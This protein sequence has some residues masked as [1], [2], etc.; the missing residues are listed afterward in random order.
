[1]DRRL[2]TRGQ[3]AIWGL[4]SMP[5]WRA[6]AFGLWLGLLAPALVLAQN[7]SPNTSNQPGSTPP[8]SRSKVTFTEQ[9]VPAPPAHEHQHRRY[10]FPVNE[11]SAD[12]WNPYSRESA[13]ITQSPLRVQQSPLDIIQELPAE[14][15]EPAQTVQ[16]HDSELVQ[17]LERVQPAER[18]QQDPSEV[19]KPDR[20]LGDLHP[21]R[22]WADGPA[23]HP[24]N[25]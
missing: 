10:S 21:T 25:P 18:A 8:R 15:V 7:A 3:Q 14:V 6:A 1:M 4:G 13:P 24:D 16:Q 19:I 2:E 17:L 20:A 23:D 12:F 22:A 11:C 5:R 9:P